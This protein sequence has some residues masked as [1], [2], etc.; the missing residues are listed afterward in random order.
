MTPLTEILFSHSSILIWFSIFPFQMSAL[1][2]FSLLFPSTS[3][4]HF[5]NGFCFPICVIYSCLAIKM[6]K[7]KKKR[8]LVGDYDGISICVL[9][10][11]FIYVYNVDSCFLRT[12]HSI[13]GIK[14]NH[15]YIS[16]WWNIGILKCPHHI[17]IDSRRCI[18][19]VTS[20]NGPCLYSMLNFEKFMCF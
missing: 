4:Q 6:K 20:K 10:L 11:K 3:P 8:N 12:Q 18:W 15:I 19:K 2:G 16:F 5:L 17:L 1:L 13:C 9:N 7:L 14:F